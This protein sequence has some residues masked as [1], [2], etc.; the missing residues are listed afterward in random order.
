MKYKFILK[1]LRPFLKFIGR[2]YISFHKPQ[3]NGEKYVKIVETLQ[4]GDILLS[5]SKGEISNYLIRSEFTHAAIYVGEWMIVEATGKG[6][7]PDFITNFCFKKDDILILRF[8][9]SCFMA[10]AVEWL[11][12]M[13]SKHLEYDMEFESGDQE[14]YCFELAAGAFE[15]ALPGLELPKKKV[16]DGVFYTCDTFL[17]GPFTQ[18]LDTRKL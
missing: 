1:I 2:I 17:L 15:Y 5:K 3:M 14:Y 18:V 10:R 9:K 16:L 7:V 11:H 13:S 4:I 12:E 6:V 8:N